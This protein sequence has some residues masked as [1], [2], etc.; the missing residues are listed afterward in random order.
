MWAI[1][2]DSN[3]TTTSAGSERLESTKW[4]VTFWAAYARFYSLSA[5][6][7]KRRCNKL[8]SSVYSLCLG[9]GIP[10]QNPLFWPE[11][12]SLH[13]F[14]Y[15]SGYCWWKS[16]SKRT[17]CL[18]RRLFQCLLLSSFHWSLNGVLSVAQ[19]P[20]VISRDHHD[21]SGTDSPF[22]ETSNVYDGSAFCAGMWYVHYSCTQLRT[23]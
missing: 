3:T 23:F 17:N 1:A 15:Q 22:R 20:V 9:C 6:L 10:S 4:S 11:R 18:L 21:V 14:G 5:N 16:F 8:I 12:K 13:C 7:M 2:S 19:A